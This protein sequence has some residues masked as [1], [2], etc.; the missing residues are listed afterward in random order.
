MLTWV[1]GDSSLP[2]V[3]HVVDL[4]LAGDP[5]M[6]S[7][8][9]QSADRVPPAQAAGWIAEWRAVM[10]FRNGTPAFCTTI[11]PLMAGAATPLRDALA[12]AYAATCRAP[13]D[14]SHLLRP[15]TPYWAVIEAYQAEDN[16]YPAP[17]D[18]RLL[19]RAAGQ[20]V[21]AGDLSALRPAAGSLA[22]RP[23][24]DA[25]AALR[26][27]HARVRDREQADQLAMAFFRTGDPQLHQLAWRAC[28]NMARPHPMCES[29][30]KRRTPSVQ[31]D[32]PPKA[33]AADI[34]VVRQMLA[35]AGFPR[36]A[37]M[38]V[39]AFDT[40][41]ATSMLGIAGHVY[42]FDAETDQ[43]PN[44]HDSL[45]RKLASLVQPALAG[46]VFEEAVPAEDV[47]PYT[48]TAYLDGKR[49]QT[50]AR[51]LD[52]WYDVETV[53]RLLNTMLA[54]R[55]RPERF[56]N[57]HTGDQTAWVVGGP[58]AAIT[59]SFE[60]GLLQPGD[61]GDAEQ[62]GKAFEAVVLKRLKEE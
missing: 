5:V 15:D 33:S 51:N 9:Q 1:D 43:F 20:A 12:G 28:S 7:A 60:S 42:A 41:D 57:L 16:G 36:V 26:A 38:P 52:D 54:D 39:A 25:W 37:E 27:L 21:D 8:V 13:E 56:A 46:A 18:R 47:G 22:D 30:P 29:G 40:V 32:A 2:P 23:E 62:S 48:L 61:A 58:Q 35:N 50:A 44:E 34:A 55:G 17:T 4:L 49:Y 11:R 3:G 53:L 19:V 24:P 10:R 59:A 6:L 14:V 45:L 31:P